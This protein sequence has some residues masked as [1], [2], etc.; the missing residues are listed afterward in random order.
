VIQRDLEPYGC[1]TD[2]FLDTGRYVYLVSAMSTLVGL[3]R[4]RLDWADALQD[5]S[6]IAAGDPEL[7]GRVASWFQRSAELSDAVIL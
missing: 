6:L 5:G 3:A 1:L 2:P 7:V 4:G